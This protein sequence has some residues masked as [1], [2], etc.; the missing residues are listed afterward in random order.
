MRPLLPLS[1]SLAALALPAGA[2]TASPA[3]S[4]PGSRLDEVVVTATRRADL[5]RDVPASVSTVS[6]D[7]FEAQGVRFAGEE[8]TGLPGVTVGTNDGGTYTGLTIR[9]VPNRI[10]NDTLAVLVDGVPYV[11]GDDEV[12][13]E[14]LPF[15]AVGRVDLVRGPM[16]ALYGRGAIAGTVN[17]LT[18]EVG[19]APRAE[20]ELSIGSFGWLRGGASVQAPTVEGGALLLSAG[21]ER[22]D[23]W[24]DRTGRN[25]ESLFAKHRLDAG[26]LGR[27]TL[28][29]S[30]TDRRQRLAGELPVTPAGEPVPLPRGRRANWNEDD[31]GFYKRMLAGTAILES[32]LA[33]G[34]AATTRL[35]ARQA[36]TSALQGFFNPFDPAAGVVTFSGFRVDG[37]TDTLFAEQ[38]VDW[39]AGAFRLLGGASAEQ[40]RAH[41]VETWTGEFDFGPKFYA[42]SRD[43]RTG[44][45][46]DR[47]LW[48]SDRL[49]DAR[50]RQ[51][52]LAAYGQADWTAGALTLSGGARY[53][54]FSRRVHYGPS[55]T[56]FGENPVE[57]VRDADGRLSPKLSATY[58]LSGAVTAYAAYGAGFSA[59]FG[60]L[61]SFRGRPAD[62][63]PELAD[64]LEAGVKGDFLQ[65][66]LTA[67]LTVYRLKRR[68]LL[69]LLPVGGTARTI[70][71]GRQRSRG[72]EL[73]ATADLSALADGLEA[74]ATYGL[75]DAVWTENR[76]LEPDTGRP[77][78]FTGRDVAGVPRHAGTLSLTQRLDRI[79]LTLR[80]WVELSG[81]YP[82]DEA[83]SV[84]AGGHALWNASL[85]WRASERLELALVGRNLANRAVDTV[86]DNNDGP[87]AAFPQPPREVLAT[88]RLSF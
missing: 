81:D 44:R 59:G 41:H 38:Q 51:R 4:Q 60:P 26:G 50:G 3:A 80:G 78:D 63:Q 79:G 30:W 61:W 74:G 46:V 67:S 65:G 55:R 7:A 77:F 87:F 53:D 84:R 27:L 49:L 25:E 71:A 73:E 6:R 31:A 13:L 35:H 28:T 83:N 75:T 64:N 17:Y 86:V 8:L 43:A 56:G 39:T 70:N 16:S 36:R 85:T 66:M 11:T 32:D 76:F 5:L 23:G 62:A 58:A 37:D 34:L 40:V 72:M 45:H 21:A 14:Q 52:N 20:A 29:A 33:P 15:G 57:T 54:R 1:L 82:Y 69:Q 42:Q 9:G 19:D 10:H 48:I 47:D 18:R 12:D 22:A 68:D 2:Q 24:R 88:A